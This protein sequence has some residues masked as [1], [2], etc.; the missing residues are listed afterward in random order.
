MPSRR[1]VATVNERARLA[2]TPARLLKSSRSQI[3]AFVGHGPIPKPYKFV[4][5]DEKWPEIVIFI[6]AHIEDKQKRMA[7]KR[8][9]ELARKRRKK[10]KLQDNSEVSSS[11]CEIENL[12]AVNDEPEKLVQEAYA[13]EAE[14]LIKEIY[15]ARQDDPVMNSQYY[16]EEDR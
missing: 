11:E 1:I 8:K 13:D 14:E 4:N 10:R 16:D 3:K 12:V 6:R 9:Q 15:E 5:E 2:H 7:V